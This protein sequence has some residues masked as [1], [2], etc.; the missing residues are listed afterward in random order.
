MEK[1]RL[2]CWYLPIYLLYY[3]YTKGNDMKHRH[4][5]TEFEIDDIKHSGFVVLSSHLKS[6]FVCLF[7]C[8]MYQELCQKNKHLDSS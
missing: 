7:L 3:S 4:Y 8:S 6:L 5:F 1:L 2:H